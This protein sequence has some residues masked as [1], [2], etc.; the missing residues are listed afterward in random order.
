VI[1]R[2]ERLGHLANIERR[3]KELEITVSDMLRKMERWTHGYVPAA[4]TWDQY[5]NPHRQ[6]RW[7]TATSRHPE[8]IPC[9]YAALGQIPAW[10]EGV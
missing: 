3:R 9:L 8:M 10:S 4:T 6:D 1:S 7:I 5:L 2:E